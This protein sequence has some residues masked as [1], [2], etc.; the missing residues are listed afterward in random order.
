MLLIIFLGLIAKL[1][2]VC[3][4]CD[5]GNQTVNNFDFTKVGITELR[6]FM[7][8]VTFKT[9]PRVCNLFVFSLTSYE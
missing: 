2:S 5:V 6:G 8:Q 9:A 1:T 3:G 7:E 4:D